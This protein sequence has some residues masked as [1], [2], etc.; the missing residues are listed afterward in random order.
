MLANPTQSGI[1]TRQSDPN[2]VMRSKNKKRDEA[3]RKRVEQELT[4]RTNK[5]RNNSDHSN[6]KKSSKGTVSSLRP[7]PA[8]IILETA[9]IIQ[10]AQ[11]MAAKRCD[12]VLA[13]NQNGNLVGILTDKDIAFRVVA[14]GLDIRTTSVQDVMTPDP[15][16]VHDHGSRNEAL[17]IM[18]SRRF[19]HLPVISDGDLDENE[20]GGTSVVG[21]LDITK[22]VFERLEDLERK[23]N[24]DQSIISA[25]EVLER[26]GSVNADR[27]DTMRNE[28]ECPTISSLLK[29]INNER[30]SFPAIPVKCSVKDAAKM[31]K[32]Y[33]STAV[34]AQGT[35]DGADKVAGIFTT[36]DIV[37]RVLAASLD[38]N[39]TSVIRVMTPH[40]D[41]VNSD[42]SILD[43]LK[44][45]HTG[46][47]LHL[48]VIDATVP[49]GLIDVMTLTIAMLTYLVRIA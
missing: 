36:K 42:A 38:P 45:L 30:G 20:D 49:M 12:A 39:T 46:H 48:P 8:I 47:F 22:C 24:E 21:L 10:A 32:L 6:Q 40:P 41:F 44:K 34:L 17:N 1:P 7:A 27:V 15:I 25:M 18:I 35:P 11:L 14:E 37:L 43:A 16:A 33:H 9:K 26:R 4:K 23:V 31:M 29:K 3:I 13:V 5:K 19:R 28:H 2:Q